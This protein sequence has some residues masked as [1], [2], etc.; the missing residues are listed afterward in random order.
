MLTFCVLVVLYFLPSILAR[1]KASFLPIFLL[2]LFLG[3]TFIFWVVA[4]IWGLSQPEPYRVIAAPARFCCS[5]GAPTQN[6]HCP[7]C[8]KVWA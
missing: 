4:L 6:A 3:W 8:G 1:N 5:C 7:H 2:N